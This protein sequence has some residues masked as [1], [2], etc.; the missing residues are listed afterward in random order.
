MAATVVT[1][2]RTQGPYDHGTALIGSLVLALVFG[3]H[4]F[5]RF[6]IGDIGLG[7]L[8]C[9][10][11]GGCCIWSIIEWVNMEQIVDDANRRVGGGNT[12]VVVTG[13]PQPVQHQPMGYPQQQ[14][15]QAPP[16]QQ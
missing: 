15:Q 4:G 9:L 12:T 10:T 14:Y 11:I 3:F 5:H 2:T 6:Y 13:S 1:T 16:Y 7:C 8:M